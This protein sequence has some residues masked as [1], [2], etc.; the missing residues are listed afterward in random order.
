MAIFF[1]I[2]VVV[3]ALEQVM[4]VYGLD[5][6]RYICL[7]MQALRPTNLP[8]LRTGSDPKHVLQVV[9]LALKKTLQLIPMAP[10][11]FEPRTNV[12][13]SRLYHH[14]AR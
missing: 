8:P 10:Q 11:G 4:E 9:D 2:V 1:P 7:A 14:W 3:V 13:R 6:G 5:L 12:F